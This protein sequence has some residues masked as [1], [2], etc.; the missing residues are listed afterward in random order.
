MSRD[1]KPPFRRSQVVRP[2]SGRQFGKAKIEKKTFDIY[3]SDIES[4]EETLAITIFAATQRE[5]IQIAK[6]RLHTS[7]V[8][9][10]ITYAAFTAIEVKS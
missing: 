2:P 4:G 9:R 7:P 5:A 10:N 1:K 8:L 6:K 3:V